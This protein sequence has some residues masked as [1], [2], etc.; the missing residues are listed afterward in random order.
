MKPRLLKM[1]LT[2]L[3]CYPL[4]C[5]QKSNPITSLYDLE[6]GMSRDT[7]LAGLAAGYQLEEHRLPDVGRRK[8]GAGE[9][10]RVGR[11]GTTCRTRQPG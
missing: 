11:Y 2:V 8:E 6:V 3:S 1:L 5:Q 9:V 4:L 10:D 7:V